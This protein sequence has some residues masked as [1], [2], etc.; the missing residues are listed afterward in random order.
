MAESKVKATSP[1]AEKVVTIKIPRTHS[2]KYDVFVSVNDRTW[3]IQ[4]GVSV[5]V[6]ECVAEAI[7]NSEAMLEEAEE[8]EQ[9]AQG[10][11][12]EH[13]RRL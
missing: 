6:P 13:A 4:R 2:E 8:F 5:E 3:M 10:A 1:D 9:V 7:A 12:T 11:A